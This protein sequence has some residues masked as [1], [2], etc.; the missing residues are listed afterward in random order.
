[1]SKKR[2]IEQHIPC[3]YEKEIL[4]KIGKNTT[5]EKTFNDGV[6]IDE[7]EK[8]ELLGFY[9]YKGEVC[10]LDGLGMDICFSEYTEKTKKIIH[11]NILNNNYY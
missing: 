10:I 4:D 11:S 9:T 7:P 3:E 2:N 6:F 5:N 1:M 8:N